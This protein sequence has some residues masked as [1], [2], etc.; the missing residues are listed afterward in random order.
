MK[1]RQKVLNKRSFYSSLYSSLYEIDNIQWYYFST[2]KQ[3]T[4]REFFSYFEN[5]HR[6]KFAILNEGSIREIRNLL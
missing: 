2:Y 4:F 6:I 1:R 5:I 3:D